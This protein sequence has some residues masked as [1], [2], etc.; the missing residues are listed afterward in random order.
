MLKSVLGVGMRAR[1]QA[2]DGSF[3][4]ESDLEIIISQRNYAV[5]IAPAIERINNPA[6]IDPPIALARA[7]I[8]GCRRIAAG[9]AISIEL[10][11]II[12]QLLLDQFQI[13]QALV[14]AALGAIRLP[15]KDQTDYGNQ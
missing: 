7:G 5:L 15:D 6:E 13:A 2:D 3:Q 1:R 11:K 8:N 10:K 12:S 14:I 4:S 9:N